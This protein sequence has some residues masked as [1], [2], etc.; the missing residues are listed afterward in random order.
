MDEISKRLVVTLLV[1]VIITTLLTTVAFFQ[2]QYSSVDVSSDDSQGKVMISII[3]KDQ[4][5]EPSG[6]AV[7]INIKGRE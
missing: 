6:A 7:S 2:L 4:P 1:T 5:Q 3:D